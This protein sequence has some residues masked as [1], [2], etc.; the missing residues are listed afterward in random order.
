[1]SI[2]RLMPVTVISYYCWLFLFELIDHKDFFPATNLN[3]INRANQS[4][5]ESRLG[6]FVTQSSMQVL[7]PRRYTGSNRWEKICWLLIADRKWDMSEW[8]KLFVIPFHSIHNIIPTYEA[9]ITQISNFNDDHVI[10][11]KDRSGS[12]VGIFFCDN[13]RNN[14]IIPSCWSLHYYYYCTKL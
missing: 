5:I 3:R 10:D 4:H 14:N 1:M 6:V 2:R 7:T 11:N 9:R 13:N 8:H 12:V